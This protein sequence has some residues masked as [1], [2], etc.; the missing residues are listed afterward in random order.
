M[1]DNKIYII[2]PIGMNHGWGICGRY[3]T[4]ELSYFCD[5]E[6]ITGDFTVG[7]VM[8]KEEF[9]HLSALKRNGDQPLMDHQ[10][11][12]SPVLQAIRGVDMEPWYQS[13]QGPSRLGYTFFEKDT[14]EP[15]A[16]TRS[17][18]Y[19]DMIVTGSS[20]CE[21]ILNDCG[22]QNT[23]T[24]IQGIDKNI[25]HPNDNEKTLHQDQ[26]VIFSGG[27]L[28]LRKGQDLV[29]RALKI[30]QDKYPDVILVNLWYNQWTRS[31]EPMTL[32]PYIR[33]EMPKA[34]YHRAINH[35]LALNGIDTRRVITLPSQSNHEMAA[36]Y[37][38]TDIGLFPNRC[39]GGTNLVL[40]EY[41]ACGKPVIASYSSGHRDILSDHNAIPLRSLHPFTVRNQDDS[42]LYNWEEP[43]L[44]EIISALEWAYWHRDA[45]KVIGRTAGEDLSKLTW[46]ESARQFYELINGSSSEHAATSHPDDVHA[47][48]ETLSAVKNRSQMPDPETILLDLLHNPKQEDPPTLR[49]MMK[50]LR[51]RYGKFSKTEAI[52]HMMEAL[53]IETTER[54]GW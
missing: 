2:M 8:D 38:N 25:F 36:V 40:M 24:I 53:I 49:D 48:P 12:D 7:D 16:I 51:V 54:R 18:E 10:I 34:D 21:R 52:L 14:I 42:I 37:K 9:I 33:F 27:K 46:K 5:V 41:M 29:I 39:E 50:H 20:W 23:Q 19:F 44:D 43:N 28:E 13:I 26:F 11:L 35:L 15:E 45:I 4:K 47:H 31:M 22:F 30:L 3:L 32:S 17:K 6:L 1:I